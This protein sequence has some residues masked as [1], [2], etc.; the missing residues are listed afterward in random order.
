MTAL[1]RDAT[2]T[3]LKAVIGELDYDLA[4]S[5]DHD[6][7]TGEDTWDEWVDKFIDAYGKA[8]AGV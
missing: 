3:G 7:E 8:V 4:K 6:E 1:N 5:L 2:L